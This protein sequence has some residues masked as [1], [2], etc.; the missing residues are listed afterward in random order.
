MSPLHKHWRL[1]PSYIEA[2]RKSRTQV[3]V[4]SLLKCPLQGLPPVSSVGR[5]ARWILMKSLACILSIG[6]PGLAWNYNPLKIKGASSL[7]YY[8]PTAYTVCN[9]SL[10]FYRAMILEVS[11]W[12]NFPRVYIH[13]HFKLKISYWNKMYGQL[14]PPKR[15][16]L[17]IDTH[18]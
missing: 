2:P 9:V 7:A 16:Y 12:L 17:I 10:F 6:T 15:A 3:S 13:K 11:V 14:I 4:S 8:W 5:L 18:E 1:W